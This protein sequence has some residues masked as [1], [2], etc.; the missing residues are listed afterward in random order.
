LPEAQKKE[1]VA[2]CAA[3]KTYSGEGGLPRSGANARD[4]GGAARAA[5]GCDSALFLRQR[6]ASAAGSFVENEL[7]FSHKT[8]KKQPFGVEY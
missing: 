5:F 3:K 1:R 7:K 6:D 2:Q 8:L 4:S